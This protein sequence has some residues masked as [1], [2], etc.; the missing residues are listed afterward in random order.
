MYAEFWKNTLYL[1]W[2][3]NYDISDNRLSDEGSAF[4]SECFHCHSDGSGAMEKDDSMATHPLDDRN[5]EIKAHQ[6]SFEQP[7]FS[8]GQNEDAQE[9][10]GETAISWEKPH[11]FQDKK[12]RRKENVS[13]IEFPSWVIALLLSDYWSNQYGHS[14]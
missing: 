4:T 7:T 13:L 6:F 3:L 14:Q 5:W 9:T 8:W 12:K 2:P 1:Q 11:F 10:S